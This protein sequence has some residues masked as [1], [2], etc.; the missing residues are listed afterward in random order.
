M[1]KNYPYKYRDFSR[2]AAEASLAAREQ[3]K[4][5]EYHEALFT[6]PQ[7]QPATYGELA[8]A[9]GIDAAKLKACL[10]SRKYEAEVQADPTGLDQEAGV[11]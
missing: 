7:L 10:D 8:R 3:G 1:I 11:P 2:I 9:V 5:W 6:A 4:Y